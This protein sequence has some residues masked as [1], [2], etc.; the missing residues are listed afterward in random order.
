MDRRFVAATRRAFEE[1]TH[2]GEAAYYHE[3]F[4]GGTLGISPEVNGADY[5]YHRSFS[6]EQDF[7][8]I[9]MAWQVHIDHCGGLPGQSDAEIIA[10]FKHLISTGTIQNRYPRVQNHIFLLAHLK[11]GQPVVEVV[12]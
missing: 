9:F 2:L 12:R 4:A 11:D 10:A 1:L 6:G 5:V 7:D 3:A 8:L